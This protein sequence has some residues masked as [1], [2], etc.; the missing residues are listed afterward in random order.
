M[1]LDRRP[2]R[3]DEQAK[4]SVLEQKLL[5]EQAKDV[6]VFWLSLNI[7]LERALRLVTGKSALDRIIGVAHL[8]KVVSH[9]DLANVAH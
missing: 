7:V 3:L 4:R 2:D 9:I 5:A 1:C 8:H 6:D